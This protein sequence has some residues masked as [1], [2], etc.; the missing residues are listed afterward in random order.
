MADNTEINRGQS[1]DLS[2]SRGRTLVDPGPYIGIVKDSTDVTL[3]GRLRVYIPEMASANEEDSSTWQT[4][5]Y[6]S[7]FYGITPNTGGK[8]QSGTYEGSRQSYGLGHTARCWH[9][10]HGDICVW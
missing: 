3:S 9:A 4:V 7:P 8:E 5:S 2:F 1:K 10:S 6:L